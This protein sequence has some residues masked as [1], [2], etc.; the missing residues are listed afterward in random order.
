MSRDSAA[1][2]LLGL[3]EIWRERVRG[4]WC[5]YND[6]LNMAYYVLI[7]DHGTDA[8]F[9]SVGLDAAYRKANDCSTFAVETHVN[10]L[11]EVRNGDEVICTTQLLDFDEKRIHFF[12]RMYH[13]ER[14]FLAATNEAMGVHVDMRVR[15][16]AP[17][18]AELQAALNALRASHRALPRPEQQGRV[19]GIPRK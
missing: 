16:V 6:H 4:E 9:D 2:D 18:K 14:G 15:K 10:Y 11:A 7:F 17:M 5:D 1:P 8:F 13:A 12:H 19:I 3:P